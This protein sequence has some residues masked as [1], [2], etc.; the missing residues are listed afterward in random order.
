VCKNSLQ[1]DTENATQ[2]SNVPDPSGCAARHR[3]FP[4][5]I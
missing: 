3:P 1:T 2:T 5:S 4:S